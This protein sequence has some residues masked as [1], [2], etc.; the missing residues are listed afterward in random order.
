MD[1]E[2]GPRA[3][4]NGPD[5]VGTGDVLAGITVP[6]FSN[7][8]APVSEVADERGLQP[9]AQSGHPGP[10]PGWGIPFCPTEV[11]RDNSI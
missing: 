6:T 3:A 2:E 5:K 4:L 1:S 11:L 9:R 8:S 10:N 7:H